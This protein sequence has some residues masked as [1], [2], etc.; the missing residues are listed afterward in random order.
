MSKAWET[1]KKILDALKTK[2][3]TLT[4]LSEQLGLSTSTVGQH[5][6]ELLDK[7][8]I[9]EKDEDSERKWKY[10]EPNPTFDAQSLEHHVFEYKLAYAAIIIVG[11]VVLA[12]L[13][14]YIVTPKAVPITCSGAAGYSCAT[15]SI[16]STG[17][18]S[19]GIAGLPQ[20]ATING[21]ACS[22][23]STT[24][25][26]FMAPERVAINSTGY[27]VVNTSCAPSG[28]QGVTSGTYH[29][30]VSYSL[31]GNTVVA[32]I[33]EIS[34]TGGTPIAAT[35]MPFP[36]TTAVTN[37]IETGLPSGAVWTVKLLN[38][39][40]T[41]SSS[42]SVPAPNKII[43]DSNNNSVQLHY[44]VTPVTFGSLFYVPVPS[45]GTTMAG[46]NLNVHFVVGGNATSTTTVPSVGV[47][48]TVPRNYSTNS[49]ST[50]IRNSSNST[51]TTTIPQG[52]GC[53]TTITVYVGNSATCSS[54]RVQV[55][56]LGQP[57]NGTSPADLNVYWAPTNATVASQLVMFPGQTHNVTY[58]GSALSIYVSN[59]YAGLYFNQKW[60]KMRLTPYTPVNITKN[61]TTGC[62]V[63]IT[64]HVGQNSTCSPF[65]VLFL[66]LGS[67]NNGTAPAIFNITASAAP[68]STASIAS[69]LVLY[70]GQSYN[71]TYTYGSTNYM[72]NLHLNKTASGLYYYQKI[73]QFVLRASN[74]IITTTTTT[75]ISNV[76]T[77]SGTLHFGNTLTCTPAV[78]KLTDL[79]QPSN[80]IA[81]G[82]FSIYDL[83]TTLFT[84][85]SLYPS[86][87]P[88]N[89]TVANKTLSIYVHSTYDGVYAYE[90]SAN[91]SIDYR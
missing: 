90:K 55:T 63:L 6:Q 71:G 2:P 75:T 14:A 28:L 24:P 38:P 18:L 47:T 43:F 5:L 33:A 66:N 69:E 58:G 83:N 39:N 32:Q 35:T 74:T 67:P 8:A 46:T 78:L 59:T 22:R 21:V 10:Y 31:D 37:V 53:N 9:K 85:Q 79:G 19:L 40:G 16:S 87:N 61:Y 27:A 1:K 44:R 48:T 13:A 56:D 30:W 60:A 80:G 34:V 15:P 72:L 42:T 52:I 81:P 7:N 49:T 12:A 25:T 20:Q 36:S 17:E 62:N 82:I 68:N 84:S 41:L 4:E 3:K 11:L 51:S 65:K 23:N 86:A 45:N 70:P 57:S 50:I 26:S 64:I 88:Y 54:F 89:Y 29:M 73:A 91:V 76:C 77:Q